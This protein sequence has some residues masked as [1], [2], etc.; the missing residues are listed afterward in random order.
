MGESSYKKMRASGMDDVIFSGSGSRPARNTAEVTLFLDNTDRTAPAAL[1]R[2]R[3]AARC[4]AASSARKARSIASTARKCAPRTCSCCSPTQSTGAHSP[5]LVGQG[6]IGEL[7]AAKPQARRALLEEAAGISGPALAPARGRTAAAGGRAESRTPRRRHRRT[8]KPDRKPE[9][10]GAPGHRAIKHLSADIRKA[11]ATL[12]HLR[13]TLAKTQEG[14]AR[15]RW[16]CH[17]TCRRP[18]RRPDGRRQGARHRRAPLARTCATRKPPPPLPSSAC[19]S[20]GADRGGSRPHPR[21]PDANSSAGCSSS[22]ATLPREGAH[23]RARTRRCS[24]ACGPKKPRSRRK[25]RRAASARPA[26]RAAFE[27]AAATLSAKRRQTR[28][29]DRRARREAAAPAQPGRTDAARD[30]GASRRVLASQSPRSTG[31]SAILLPRSPALPDPAEKRVLVEAAP[32]A[33]GGGRG[34]RGGD[35]RSR[36]RRGRAPPKAAA[37]RRCRRPGRARADR[38]RGANAGQDSQCRQR[39]AV[40]GGARADQRRAR[41]SRPRSARRSATISRRRSTRGAPLHWARER[42]RAR[43]PGPAG[44]RDACQRR[45]APAAAAPAVWT[46]I[47]IVDTADGRRLQALLAP[48]QRLVSREGALWR[49]DGLTAS[50]DAP[51]AA[52]QRLAQTNRLAE[53]DAEVAGDASGCVRPRRR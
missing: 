41:A 42:D 17:G 15:S 32:G 47:G 36:R 48:G 12:L 52:A 38:D 6:H 9:A 2:C 4:R 13:W 39:R 29:A 45:H 34:R 50:A 51:T 24:S 7:I 19:R 8:G 11:E 43:R 21:P 46:Q 40:A 23:G 49:W 30:R 35:R 14:E 53:L 22:T 3:R 20:P 37:G 33:L 26:P 44:R 1:Q 10:P 18:R 16:R 31:V 25:T 27:Q 28:R 5:S